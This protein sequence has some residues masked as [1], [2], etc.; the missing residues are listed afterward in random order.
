MSRAIVAT[1]A[2]LL[3]AVG[4]TVTAPARPAVAAVVFVDDHIHLQDPPVLGNRV[5]TTGG[6]TA[7]TFYFTVVYDDQ[8]AR[9]GRLCHRHDHEFATPARLAPWT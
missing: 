1:L 4:L 6:T 7:T 5:A 9:P 2:A 3:L 8:M